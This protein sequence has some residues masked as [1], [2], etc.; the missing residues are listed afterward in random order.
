MPT[1]LYMITSLSVGGAQ[2]ALLNLINSDISQRFSP[3]VVTLMPTQGLQRVFKEAGIPVVE[4]KANKILSLLLLPWY[5]WRLVSTL[6]PSVIHGWMHH[7]NILAVFAWFLMGRK[8]VLLWGMHHTPEKD[9][10]KR[11]QHAL[12]LTLGKWLSRFPDNILYV[13][14]R[15]LERHREL[16]YSMNRSQVLANGIAVQGQDIQQ[17][18]IDVRAELN[19]A[20]NATVIGSLTRFV[21]EKDI[22]NLIEA[23]RR[24]QMLEANNNIHFLLAGEGM[25]ASNPQLMHLCATLRDTAS[26]HCLGIRADAS[27]LIAA[28]DIATLSSRREAFPLF[29]AE[30]MASGIP[31]VATDV[32]DVAEAIGQTGLVVP[33]ENPEI[34]ALAWQQMLKFSATQRQQYGEAAKHRIQQY[35]N[36]DIVVEFYKKLLKDA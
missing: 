36:M 31:C 7:G 20:P 16:G 23:I 35:Y 8:P 22:P 10:F 18:R 21:P 5:L 32:G 27:R 29:I 17:A 34:L 19:I 14:K 4:L 28:L 11:L 24:F 25:D 3:V 6:N 13:S 12:V 26:V 9:T 1:I 33:K 2:K 15:S 30:A